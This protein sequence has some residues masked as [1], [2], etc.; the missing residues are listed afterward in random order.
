[1][2][3]W[4]GQC[5]ARVHVQAHT[6]HR[7]RQHGQR[8]QGVV[9]QDHFQHSPKCVTDASHCPINDAQLPLHQNTPAAPYLRLWAVSSISGQSV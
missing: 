9:H 6:K 3:G 8:K 4:P 2:Q 7:I 5:A 1:M